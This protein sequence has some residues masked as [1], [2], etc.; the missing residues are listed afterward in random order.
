MNRSKPRATALS[1]S[2]ECSFCLALAITLC[3]CGGEPPISGETDDAPPPPP[4]EFHV[5]P[6]GSASGEG[7]PEAPFATIE[8]ARDKIRSLR[9]ETG[10]AGGAIVH[11]AGG[12]YPLGHSLRFMEQDSG[13]E[14]APIVYRAAGGE[15]AVLMG[16]TKI[17]ESAL[18]P[19]ADP[20]LV[21]RLADPAAAKFILAVD[22]RAL[23]VADVGM[24]SRRGFW[25]A[26]ELTR[27]PP[28]KLFLD[29]V[30]QTLARWPNRGETVRMGEILDPGPLD[31]SPEGLTR[32]VF[33]KE[34]N[35]ALAERMERKLGRKTMEAVLRENPRSRGREL[36]EFLPFGPAL[37]VK[38][39]DLHERGGTFAF[40][41]DRP[42]QWRQSA[43]IWI[44]G[45]FGFSWEYSYNKVARIDRAERTITL[46]YGE[47]SGLNRNW[48]EDFHHFEN[49]FEEIDSPGEY[50]ID[51]ESM[52]LYFY[53]PQ[54]KTGDLNLVLSTLE[55]PLL[56]VSGASHLQFKGLEFVGGRGDG[57]VVERS[58]GVVLSD[59][60]IQSL[61][62]SGAV[63]RNSVQSGLK[64][65][66]IAHV[67]STGVSLGGGEWATLVPG[68]NFVEQCLIHH[69]AFR[70]KAYKPGVNF[71]AGSVGNRV[72]GSVIHSAPQG[73]IILYGNDHVVEGN[74]LHSLCSEFVDFGAIYTNAGKNP[75]DR[76]SRISGNYIHG[77]RPE[78]DHGV[79]GIY[80]DVANFEVMARNNVISD[81]G[82]NAITLKGHH[83]LVEDNLIVNVRQSAGWV[84]P[85]DRLEEAHWR[86][87]FQEHPP[88]EA[89]HW[90]SYPKLSRFWDDVEEYG[91]QAGPLNRFD[92][93]VIFDPKGYLREDSG[94]ILR[95]DQGLAGYYRADE[96]AYFPEAEGNLMLTE[97]PGFQDWRQGNFR[98]VG[99]DPF[100]K[101]RL[102][103]LNRMFDERGRFV[104]TIHAGIREN[105]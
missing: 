31:L 70:E 53:P 97:D 46:R 73:G 11:L 23:G 39:P 90:R 17:P 15:P 54:R 29:G 49:I 61:S 104:P 43:D 41:Y 37:G 102:G 63:I 92:D 6:H 50:F 64:H 95:T 21:A 20:D 52:K 9:E 100:L 74:E 18:E 27:T 47:M 30:P 2:K 78:I 22:L 85:L 67:G 7:T 105:W 16:G 44:S 40:D 42:L 8:R 25:K 59:C 72:L 65:C 79:V 99:N 68:G 77:I 55:Q 1:G 45:I 98:Y 83:L 33:R 66:E 94:S 34:G 82:G 38:T 87:L 5:S 62:G 51:R 28:S 80:F 13:T 58:R 36:E 10:L 3:G 76:G 32:F 12:I 14:G 96:A 91:I 103:Y 69:F 88:G 26:S 81:I 56:R 24:L 93:N 19:L 89:P 60:L 48:Y 84:A 35:E 57:V 101:H 86:K 4:L 71:N 75:M